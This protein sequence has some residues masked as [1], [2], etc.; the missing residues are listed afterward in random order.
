MLILVLAAISS[1]L[2]GYSYALLLSAFFLFLE[3]FY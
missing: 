3:P 1:Y 2:I